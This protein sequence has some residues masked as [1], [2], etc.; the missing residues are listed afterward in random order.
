MVVELWNSLGPWGWWIVGI[1]LLV[2]ELLVPGVFLIWIGAAAVVLGAL[3]LALWDAE[4]W[5]WHVQ[6]L[7]FAVLSVLFAVIGRRI[8]N[9]KRTTSDEPWLNRRG[10]SLIGRTA[11]LSEPIQE[12]RGRIRLD[13]TMWSVM[14]PDL[15]VGSR[16]RVVAS[17]GRDLTVEPVVR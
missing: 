1:A 10:E 7:L 12:G 17:S 6:L 3:S 8:Y 14:G 4:F 15:P 11:T 2:L 9:G 16:V 5:G 13:D